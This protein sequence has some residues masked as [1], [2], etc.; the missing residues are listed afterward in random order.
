MKTRWRLLPGP[1][2]LPLL[3]LWA[4][5]ALALPWLPEWLRVWQAAGAAL[6]VLVVMEGLFLWRRRPPSVARDVPAS[7][8]LG[9]WREVS[10]TFWHDSDDSRRLQVADHLPPGCESDSEQ[11]VFTLT[12]GEALRLRYRL[13]ANRRGVHTFPG[14][15]LRQ[16]TLLG[17]LTRQDF[18]PVTSTV[19]VY[20]NFA[21]VAKYTLLA[22]DNRLSQLG[23]RLRRRRGA[24]MEFHQLREYRE[25]DAIK[26]ID[27]KATSRLRKLI[28]REYQDE[29]DQQVMLLLDGGFRMRSQDGR[30]SHFDEALNALLL[31][32]YS[33]QRQGDAVGLMTFANRECLLPP[34]KGRAVMNRFM[35][36]VFDLEPS[37]QTPDFAS[38]ATRLDTQVRK[39]SLLILITSLRDEDTAELADACRRLGERHLVLVANLREKILDDIDASE[40]GDVDSALTVAATHRYLASRERALA[41]LRHNGVIVLDTLPEHLAVGLINR[42][43]E[44]KRSGRL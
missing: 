33:V 34:A 25:G 19:R 10:L 37:G 22:S 4:A 41:Q 42:Y 20:P 38:L 12:S 28:A 7:L 44:I 31:L 39:R 26:Q 23:I 32:T 40:P 14:L 29:R 15:D 3:G 8:P 35:N 1:H 5:I 17:L 24:G 13:R 21:E 36:A 27:W 30:L 11:P 18:V 2:L 16:P 43:L 6:L 9:V